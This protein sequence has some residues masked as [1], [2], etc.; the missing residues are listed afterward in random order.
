[1]H[2]LHQPWPAILGG[3]L[4]LMREVVES[5][6]VWIDNKHYV[7]A[8]PSVSTRRPTVRHVFLTPERHGALA[9]VASLHTQRH[10][11]VEH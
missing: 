9:T 7:A 1:V 2:I 6:E 10:S 3:E 11:I 8:A 5:I 4:L